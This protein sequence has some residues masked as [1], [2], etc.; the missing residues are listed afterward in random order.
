MTGDE[1]RP[2]NSCVCVRD[3]AAGLWF[4]DEDAE[5]AKC[6]LKMGIE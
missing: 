4:S 6:R 2:R 3:F 5:K 1:F